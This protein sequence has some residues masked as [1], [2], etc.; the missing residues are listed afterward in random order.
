[1]L[2]LGEEEFVRELNSALQDRSSES[3]MV[4]SLAS[5]LDLLLRSITNPPKQIQDKPPVIT[6]ST[7]C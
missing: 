4:N 1:M 7:T 5:S 6:G 3:G 2:K